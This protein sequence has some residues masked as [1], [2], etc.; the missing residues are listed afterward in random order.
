MTTT[1]PDIR[2]EQRETAPTEVPPLWQH[3]IEAVD[4]AEQMFATGVR[5]TVVIACGGGKTR[6]G[7]EIGRRVAPAGRVV[8]FAHTVD[9]VVQNLVAWV[10]H[11]GAELGRI[12]LVCSDQEALEQDTALDVPLPLITVTTDA[13]TLAELARDDGPLLVVSTYQ[14]LAVITQAHNQHQMREFDLAVCDEGHHTTGSV[15]GTW[16]GVHESG[17]LRARRRL[18]LTA[19]PRIIDGKASISMA[20]PTLFGDIHTALSYSRGR[21]DGILAPYRLVG[22]VITDEQMHRLVEAQRQTHYQVGNVGLSTTMLA[23][24][25]A[26]LRAAREHGIRTLI[27]YHRRVAD[28]QWFAKTLPG[29]A[30]FVGEDSRPAGPIRTSYVHGNQTRAERRLALRF[31]HTPPADGLVVCANAR[32]LLEGADLPGMGG[33][34][35]VDPMRSVTDIVQ[36]MGRALRTN[37]DPNKV[38]TIIVPVFLGPN[39]DPASALQRSHFN[40]LWHTVQALRATD[41]SLAQRL[42]RARGRL[43]RGTAPD[44]GALDTVPSGELPS[45]LSISGIPV[46]GDFASKLLLKTVLEATDPWQER[47]DAFREYRDENGDLLIPVAFV[48]KYGRPVGKWMRTPRTSYKANQLPP[49]RIT[50]ANALGV[51]WDVLAHNRQQAVE[52]LLSYGRHFKHFRIPA[53]YSGHPGSTLTHEQMVNA[54]QSVRQWYK[55]D[56]LELRHVKA[57]QAAGFPWAPRSDFMP[58]FLAD[59]AAYRRAHGDVDVPPSYCTPAVRGNKPRPLGRQVVGVRRQKAPLDPEDL[60]ALQELG[61][62]LTANAREA[63]WKHHVAVLAAYLKTSDN[64]RP[65]SKVVFRNVRIGQW[66]INVFSRY[67]RGELKEQQVRDLIAIGVVLPPLPGSAGRKRS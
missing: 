37:G 57:L 24:Q 29:T 8:V 46:P 61:F 56:Q 9:L 14:S 31:L 22:A 34:A 32:V 41:D 10:K 47:L 45:W 52:A 33:V 15:H 1:L 67:K 64:I 16:T 39:E 35:L 44:G 11:R 53:D 4:N 43:G 23:A 58:Q 21:E 66:L 25:M 30:Q 62:A 6:V 3:Q 55:T 54:A 60:E 17:Q 20:N 42:D 5:H 36:A 18:F 48:D 12:V 2:V 38:A 49:E 26:V 65:S 7:S 28:A 59:L 19:T 13:R 27:T 63:Q 50:D 51:V 40:D